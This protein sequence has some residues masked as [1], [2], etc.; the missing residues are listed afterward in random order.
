[1]SIIELKITLEYIEPAVTRTLQAQANI[2]LDRLHLTI[3]AA[4]GW[5]NAHLYMFEAG[6]A[7]WG[8]PPSRRSDRPTPGGDRFVR[9]A[10]NVQRIP[11]PSCLPSLFTFQAFPL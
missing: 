9:P 2:R 11:S 10:S 4:M 6:G 1:M 8:L 3:Q 5:T 7:T